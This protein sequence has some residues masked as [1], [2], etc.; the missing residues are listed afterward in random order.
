MPLVLCTTLRLL[1]H[2][3]YASDAGGNREEVERGILSFLL[4]I[5]AETR[6]ATKK[7]T[8]RRAIHMNAQLREHKRKIS[9]T[10]SQ[11]TGYRSAAPE[12]D[13][14]MELPLI[15]QQAIRSAPFPTL[16]LA[17]E[18]WRDGHTPDCWPRFGE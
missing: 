7:R 16:L 17:A 14:V 3:M 9:D 8:A 6:D 15:G 4:G 2:F 11:L 12:L 1:G 13:V 5:N 18:P 10:R